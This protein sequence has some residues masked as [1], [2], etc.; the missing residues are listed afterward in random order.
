MI[1]Q[2]MDFCTFTN[3]A[4]PQQR[5]KKK[6]IFEAKENDTTAFVRVN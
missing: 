1:M 4:K 2:K 5:K 6:K 3:E